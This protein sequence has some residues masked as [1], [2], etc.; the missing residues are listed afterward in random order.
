MPIPVDALGRLTLVDPRQRTIAIEARGAWIE[1]RFPDLAT[2][3][4]AHEAFTRHGG[5]IRVM[6]VLQREL[7]RADLALDF[8]VH[9]VSVARLRGDS[10]GSVAARALQLGGTELSLF[11]V[12]RAW[13]RG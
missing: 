13:W 3:R 9:G 1:V 2:A 12:L 11:G 4:E 7:R 10:R 6:Q 8:R 5:S